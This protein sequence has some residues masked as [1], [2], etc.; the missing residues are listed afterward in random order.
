[1]KAGT[2]APPDVPREPAPR[3]PLTVHVPWSS[4]TLPL[5]SV[6]FPG[7]AFDENGRDSAAIQILSALY[8]GR[9]SDLYKKLVVIEQK[10][11]D[12]DV[13]T[14]AG[15]D[16]SLFTVLARVKKA[17]D[18]T[19][20]RDQILETIAQARTWLAPARRVADAKSYNRYAFARTLDSTE[21]IA[22]VLSR[23]V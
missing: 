6:G 9:T 11:D 12:L 7:P 20:I 14:P 1:W 5:V 22:S 19:Y 16:P 4:T 10:V 8:F 2:A 3:G 17:D 21:R 18:A 15:F 23:Y 13:D